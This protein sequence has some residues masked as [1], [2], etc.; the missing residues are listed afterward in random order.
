VPLLPC[1]DVEESVVFYT[2]LGFTRT[3]RQLRPNPYAVVERG[4]IVIHLFGIEG[5]VPEDSYA[6]ILIVTTD[7]DGLY[8]AFAAGLREGL[9]R[10]PVSGIP[11]MT[12]P[13]RKQGTT[14]G[15]SVV[16][17]GGNWLRVSRL[18]DTE[19]GE[20]PESALG[21]V[22]ETAARQGDARGDDHTAIAALEAGLQR[23]PDAPVADR[24]PVLVYLAELQL[25]VG[26]EGR[27]REILLGVLGLALTDAERSELSD[28]IAAATELLAGLRA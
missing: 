17:P 2:M 9:G 21:R 5:F 15:F 6:S 1:R 10:L 27:A 28:D 23:H 13:R 3:Y 25:R 7:L 4:D 8:A 26:D 14:G 22:L 20:R 19:D 12:R 18:G 24:V 16:D 11:R